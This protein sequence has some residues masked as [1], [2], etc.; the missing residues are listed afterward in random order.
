M[1]Y[2]CTKQSFKSFVI[3]NRRN[4]DASRILILDVAI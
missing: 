1:Y 3:K 2:F 4:D